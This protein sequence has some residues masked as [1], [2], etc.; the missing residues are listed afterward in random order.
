ML[1]LMKHRIPHGFLVLIAVLVG[2]GCKQA[3]NPDPQTPPAKSYRIAYNIS[4]D[5]TGRNYQIWSMKPDGSDKQNIVNHQEV[6]W[7]YYAWKDRL[8]FISDRDTAYRNYYL[9]EMDAM[10]KGVKKVSGLRLEDSWMGARNDG[11]ELVVSGRIG[12]E[13]RY[14]LFIIDTETGA[15]RQITHDTAAIYRDPIFSPDGKQ[16]VCAYVAHK[17]DTS[18]DEE[19]FVMNDDGTAMKQ[20]THFPAND[21]AKYQYGYKAGP[22]HWHPTENF[23]SYQSIQGGKSG[24]YAVT[25]DGSKQWQLL[26]LEGEEGWHDWSNDGKWLA[27]ELYDDKT[28]RYSIGLVDWQSKDMEVKVLTD[29]S[30]KY[31]HAP[32]FVEVA[33]ETSE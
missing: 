19:L 7:T 10:G 16:I 4:M 21:P 8:F 25:P 9:Y 18:A 2:A 6:S 15:F 20:L 24:L 28:G 33:A 32:V 11:K 23:I 14:Q 29:S 31:Q 22:P 30:Y 17:R 3:S 12:K 13:V 5:T 26:D 27:V 1:D